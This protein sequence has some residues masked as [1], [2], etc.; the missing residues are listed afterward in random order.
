MTTTTIAAKTKEKKK[1]RQSLPN[2]T[3]PIQPAPT[4]RPRA[5]SPTR[6]KSPQPS[7]S[8]LP[9]QA[10]PTPSDQPTFNR[11]VRKYQPRSKDFKQESGWA[12]WL[13]NNAGK[14]ARTEESWQKVK[15]KFRRGEEWVNNLIAEYGRLPSQGIP[16]QVGSMVSQSLLNA[17]RRKLEEQGIDITARGPRGGTI[18]VSE[19][20]PVPKPKKRKRQS[21]PAR[22]KTPVQTDVGSDSGDSHEDAISARKRAKQEAIQK[23]NGAPMGWVYETVCHPPAQA[24]D[25]VP[26]NLP[27][28]RKRAM[29]FSY[30]E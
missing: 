21:E 1:S 15:H 11:E 27:P 18:H 3:R 13:K 14:E 9:D 2:P 22:G 16:G 8:Q 17:E 25:A 20:R 24:V 28:R 29:T 5:K 23:R 6:A 10:S 26:E 12:R 19:T 30:A 7:S 4:P